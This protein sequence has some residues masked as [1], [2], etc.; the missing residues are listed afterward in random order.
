MKLVK[1]TYYLPKE[2]LQE[3]NVLVEPNQRNNFVVE[4]IR[5]ALELEKNKLENAYISAAKDQ[6]RLSEIQEW[7]IL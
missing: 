7:S 4:A 3:I 1:A 6:L 5:V 2:I